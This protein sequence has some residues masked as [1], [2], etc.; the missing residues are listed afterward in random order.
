VKNIGLPVD[1]Y[2]LNKFGSKNAVYGVI[3]SHLLEIMTPIVSQRPHG[4]YAVPLETVGSYTERHTLQSAIEE[5]LHKSHALAL[6]GLGGTGKTQLALRY[7]QEHKEDYDPILWIDARD[8][9]TTRSSFVRCA[10]ELQLQVN[11]A[12]NKG[13]SLTDSVAVQAVLR[14][15]RDRKD[16]DDEWLVVVDNADDFT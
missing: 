15:L 8:Q 2:G 9:E 10:A 14:W 16:S 12:S 13:S 11:T 6:Y 5:K 1:H 7:V 3:L 4:L